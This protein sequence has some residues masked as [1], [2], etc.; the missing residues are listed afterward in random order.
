[1][2]AD[3][4]AA[5]YWAKARPCSLRGLTTDKVPVSFYQDNIFYLRNFNPTWRGVY[6]AFSICYSDT[7]F[8]GLSGSKRFG[9]LITALAGAKTLTVV[10]CRRYVS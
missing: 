2:A 1:M 3:Q 5:A 4:L 8:P 7:M 6:P 10:K 9:G